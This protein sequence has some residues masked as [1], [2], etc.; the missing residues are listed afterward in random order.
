MSGVDTGEGVLE[1]IHLI[2]PR[3]V[4]FISTGRGKEQYFMRSFYEAARQPKSILEV[5]KASHGIAS[6]INPREYWEEVLGV[7]DGAL[8][9]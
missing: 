2:Y 9:A 7:F 4:L 1:S 6:A 8:K 3:P 5:P